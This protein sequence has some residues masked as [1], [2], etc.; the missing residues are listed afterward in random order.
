V[1]S[2]ERAFDLLAKTYVDSLYLMG[3]QPNNSMRKLMFK[4]DDGPWSVFDTETKELVPVSVQDITTESI[5]IEGNIVEDVAVLKDLRMFVGKK[6]RIAAAMSLSD[7]TQPSPT[8]KIGIL[9]R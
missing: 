7:N 1:Q 9:A 6:V 5:L 3:Y 2:E 8:L 4:V